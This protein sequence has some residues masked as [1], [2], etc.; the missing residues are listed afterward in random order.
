MRGDRHSLCRWLVLPDGISGAQF[1]RKAAKR[2]AAVY[3]AEHFAV[4]KSIPEN[5]VRLAICAPDS[6]Q[7]LE[8]ALLIIKDILK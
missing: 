7:Q 8:D 5:G 2:G 3:G 1:E 6:M 4:G